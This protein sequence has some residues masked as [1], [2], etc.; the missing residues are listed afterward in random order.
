MVIIAA[1]VSMDCCLKGTSSEGRSARP[2]IRRAGRR[3]QCMVLLLPQPGCAT[4]ERGTL[5]DTAGAQWAC[6]VTECCCAPMLSVGSE[7]KST[8]LL[9]GELDRQKDGASWLGTWRFLAVQ[10]FPFRVCSLVVR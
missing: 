1:V 7:T 9:G 8:R 10:A 6:E 4:G 3:V 2:R 5:C